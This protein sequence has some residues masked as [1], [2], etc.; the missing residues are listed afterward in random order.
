MP[1]TSAHSTGRTY[2]IRPGSHGPRGKDQDVRMR[3]DLAV[4]TGLGRLGVGRR[5]AAG[6]AYGREHIGV[7]AVLFLFGGGLGEAV[8]PTRLLIE[9]AVDEVAAE[10]DAREGHQE[11]QQR[12]ER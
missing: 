4:A 1:P 12:R 10:C 2:R 5:L 7:S 3:P 11:H 8:M 9:F 6:M